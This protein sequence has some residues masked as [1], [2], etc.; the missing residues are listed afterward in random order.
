MDAS[1][2][3][4]ALAAVELPNVF[5]PYRDV[6]NVADAADA[7][8]IRRGNLTCYFE[9]LQSA[10]T[11]LWLGRDLGY[12]GGRRTG[13]ALTDEF[14][15]ERLAQIYQISGLTKATSDH[16]LEKERTATEVWKLLLEIPQR[17]FLWNAFPFHPHEPGKPLTNRRHTRREFSLCADVLLELVAF[18]RPDPIVALGADAERAL[19]QLGLK[20][21]RVR[22]PSY[23]G[24]TDFAKQIR[25]IYEL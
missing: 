14:H 20:C 24:Q 11:T 9:A 6:C 17:V 12:R 18:L 21:R 25:A 23:G 8:A 5:N 4:C 1:Q 22:H 10:D 19:L 13:I 7:P 3:V 2:F 16:K 15:L